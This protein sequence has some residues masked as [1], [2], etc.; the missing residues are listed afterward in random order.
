MSAVVV[1]H[2]NIEHV[3]TMSGAG[4][5]LGSSSDVSCCGGPTLEFCMQHRVQQSLKKGKYTLQ[6]AKYDS[7]RRKGEFIL[8]FLWSRARGPPQQ[9]IHD[10]HF[11]W[12]AGWGEPTEAIPH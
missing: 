10:V 11:G 7:P 1:V 3:S 8:Y 2:Q 6:K 4:A 12:G 5:D 9:Q